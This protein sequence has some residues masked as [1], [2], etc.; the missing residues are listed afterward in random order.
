M[1]SR[2]MTRRSQKA[3]DRVRFSVFIH[4]SDVNTNLSYDR[5]SACYSQKPTTPKQIK[6]LQKGQIILQNTQD[7]KRNK[8]KKTTDYLIQNFQPKTP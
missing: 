8:N 4:L 5:R 7:Y 6:T 3:V 1:P 2:S